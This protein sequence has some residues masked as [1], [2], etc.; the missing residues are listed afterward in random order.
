MRKLI[1]SMNVTLDGFMA[2]SNSEL[3]WHFRSWT[4]EMTRYASEQLSRADTI[5]LG[6]IT[7]QAMAGYW[8]DETL[9]ATC[10]REDVPFADMMNNYN[11]IVFSKSLQKAE[12]RNSTLAKENIREQVLKLKRKEGKNIIV[13]GSGKIAAALI[14][15]NLVDEYMLWVH[16]V[17]LGKGRPLFKS[18][19][20]DL[21][22]KLMNTRIFESGV[23]VLCYGI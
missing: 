12:W 13:Y 20:T 22:L 2:G 11:K 9:N 3:D 1:L 6:R 16:P 15:L 5:L 14:K 23:V 19:H 10:P 7:Y 18:L 8:S 21:Q 4:N 17:V